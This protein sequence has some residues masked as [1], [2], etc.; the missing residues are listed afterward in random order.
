MLHR[1]N[2]NLKKFSGAVKRLQALIVTA[3]SQIHYL[4]I[5]KSVHYAAVILIFDH[6]GFVGALHACPALWW[7]IDHLRS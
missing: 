6:S 4:D 5:S 1:N 3:R 7:F 2:Y